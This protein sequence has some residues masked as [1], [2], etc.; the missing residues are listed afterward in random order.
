MGFDGA[1]DVIRG[2]GLFGAAFEDAV[3]DD[4]QLFAS[5]RDEAHGLAMPMKSAVIDLMAPGDVRRLEPVAAFLLDVFA[6]R[7]AADGA[8]SGV[9]LNMRL[10][11]LVFN[12]RPV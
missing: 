12:E 7:V 4:P 3:E 9:A 5:P 1:D 8:F 11:F 6:V 10:K 2:D